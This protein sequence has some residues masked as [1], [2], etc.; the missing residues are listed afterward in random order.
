[1]GELRAK[2]QSECTVLGDQVRL[3]ETKAQYW[4]AGL[5]NHFLNLSVLKPVSSRLVRTHCLSSHLKISEP[6]GWRL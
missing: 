2:R 3:G 5:E 1:M 6:Q 4:G